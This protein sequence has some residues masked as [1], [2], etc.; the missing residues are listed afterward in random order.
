MH[1][2]CLENERID[3]DAILKDAFLE[4]I[5]AGSIPDWIGRPPVPDKLE[6]PLAERIEAAEL[7]SSRLD[8]ESVL[9]SE[10]HIEEQ[11]VAVSGEPETIEK[12]SH[13]PCERSNQSP[14][15]IEVPQRVESS[16]EHS[17][18]AAST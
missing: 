14:V 8:Q 3:Q 11:T 17:K 13:L 4:L 18:S 5:V 12:G 7:R 1:A 10:K 2:S 15:A 9:S 6:S 16:E